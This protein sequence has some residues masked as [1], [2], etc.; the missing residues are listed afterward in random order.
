MSHESLVEG[1]APKPPNPNPQQ[2][3]GSMDEETKKFIKINPRS[4]VKRLRLTADE[5][6]QL[7]HFLEQRNLQ[8][9]NFCNALLRKAVSADFHLVEMPDN[10]VKPSFPLKEKKIYRE[11]PKVSPELLFELGR[12]GTNLN[13]CARALNVIKNDRDRELDISQEFNFLECLQ[14]LKTIEDEIHSVIGEVK[15]RKM[16]EKAIA[17]ARKRAIQAV[18]AVKEDSDA[19]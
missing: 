19:Q 8:F 4:A 18:E 6:A 9:S 13:Q 16:S 7:D 11:P 5:N 1:F 17:N 12:I 3:S 15:P 2:G 14:V 10:Y